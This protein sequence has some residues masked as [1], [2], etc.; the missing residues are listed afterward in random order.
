MTKQDMIRRLKNYEKT[1]NQKEKEDDVEADVEQAGEE[2]D[3]ETIPE[4]PN[5]R[6]MRLALI[7][8]EERKFDSWR[9]RDC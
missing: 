8:A 6:Q 7:R 2:S 5:E 4:E 9:R 3:D 1:K